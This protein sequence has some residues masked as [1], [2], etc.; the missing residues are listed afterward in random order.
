[1]NIK[2]SLGTSFIDSRNWG[3]S[4]DQPPG[5]GERS[6]RRNSSTRHV[7]FGHGVSLRLDQRWPDVPLFPH[8]SGTVPASP[9]RA[10]QVWISNTR[11]NVA[12]DHQLFAFVCDT[13]I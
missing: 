1:M 12:Y 10:M 7:S 3:S 4:L 2:V 6:R 13:L 11:G 8:K 9:V 5:L